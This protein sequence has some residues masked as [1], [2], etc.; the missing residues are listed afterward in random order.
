MKEKNPV[1]AVKNSEKWREKQQI[2][3]KAGNIQ[4]TAD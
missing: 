1:I 3:K 2:K 4:I